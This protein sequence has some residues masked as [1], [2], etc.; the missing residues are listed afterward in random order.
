MVFKC[1]NGLVHPYLCRKFKTRSEVHNCNTRNRDR[2]HT[3]FSIKVAPVNMFHS[4][5][6]TMVKTLIAGSLVLF[7]FIE[8]METIC[9]KAFK[10]AFKS[11]GC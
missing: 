2:L 4:L 10:S 9:E 8:V 3:P 6:C 11:N 5:R 1:L 7:T